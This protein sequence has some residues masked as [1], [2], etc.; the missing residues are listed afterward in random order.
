[1]ALALKQALAA[2]RS[3]A[4]RLDDRQRR[5]LGLL[6]ANCGGHARTLQA[7]ATLITSYDALFMAIKAL[8][9]AKPSRWLLAPRAR[10]FAY[11]VAASIRCNSPRHA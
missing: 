1:M 9:L 11:S 8:V 3:A 2:L 6:V 4:A 7:L 5:R 10:P